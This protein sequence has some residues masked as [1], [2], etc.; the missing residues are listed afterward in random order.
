MTPGYVLDTSV[1]I[2]WYRQSEVLAPQA[3][4]LMAA[5]Y[6][7]RLAPPEGG[8]AVARARTTNHTMRCIGL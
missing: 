8:A 2:K 1:V 5:R 4:E 6:S 3:P 7:D